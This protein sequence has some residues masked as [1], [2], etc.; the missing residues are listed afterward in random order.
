MPAAPFPMPPA[1]A[2]HTAPLPL[3]KVPRTQT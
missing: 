3:A 1:G 2:G